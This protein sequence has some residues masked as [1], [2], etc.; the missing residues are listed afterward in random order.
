MNDVP[1]KV[2]EKEESIAK[3]RADLLRVDYIDSRKIKG[4]D[5]FPELITIEDIDKYKVVPI[6]VDAQRIQLGFSLQTPQTSL[7]D[8]QSLFPEKR[9]FFTYI[10]QSGYNEIR[11]RYYEYSKKDDPKPPSPEELADQLANQVLE[12]NKKL[13]SSGEINLFDE[14][15]KATNQDELFNFIVQQGYLLNSSDIHIEAMEDNARVRFRIDGRLHIVGTIDSEKYKVLLNGIQM[16]ANIRWNADYPQTGSIKTPLINNDK[17]KVDVNMR[18]ETMPTRQGHDIVIRIFSMQEKFLN[19]D[20]LGFSEQQRKAIDSIIQKPYGLVLIVGPT[21][22]GKSSTL[23]SVIRQLNSPEVKIVTL[24]DPVEYQIE[25]IT[26]INVKPKEED[27]EED[28]EPF[29]EWL[30]AVMRGDPDIIMVGE[31][32]DKETARTALQASLTGHLVLSSFHATNGA[33]ALSRILDL[34][35]YNPLLAS[36]IRLIMPQRL[37]RRLCEDCK[38][39]Y[40]P[41]K[42]L[43]EI[44]AQILQGAPQQ[45]DKIKLYK[46]VGCSKCHGIGY[47]G[48]IIVSEQFKITPSIKEEVAKKDT[49]LSSDK[50][51]GLAVA[52][53][54]S[55]MLQDGVLKAIEGLTSIDEVFRVVEF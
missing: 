48:R 29:M 28:R 33:A 39:S 21:G 53:G 11:E 10:S 6:K 55:T 47:K 51:Q 12:I 32:R 15:L 7:E 46:P 42:E 26:Q 45:P 35:D 36:A 38:K 31:I 52:D 40:E 18:I 14:G 23:Y 22:S 41:D 4:S 25:G 2:R 3:S 9:V 43:A 16:K 17:E 19:L 50:L 5:F 37:L 8:I 27:E 24:E 34:I 54:M 49:V 1:S 30:G 44:V 13:N 20:N